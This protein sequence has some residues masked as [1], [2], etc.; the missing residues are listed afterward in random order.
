MI[1]T[2]KLNSRGEL[3]EL[4]GELNADNV[5]EFKREI[6]RIL[7]NNSDLV[8]IN[9]ENLEEI[10]SSGIGALLSLVC[11][12]RAKTGEVKLVRLNGTVKKLFEL[13]RIHHSI[14]IYN[15]LEHA[16]N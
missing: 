13:L 12:M 11:G 2:R 15:S 1:T 14:S 8:V 7:N 3:I 4:S 9:F 5:G 6:S 16:L 10:D